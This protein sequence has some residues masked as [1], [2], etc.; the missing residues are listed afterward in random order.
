MA[1]RGLDLFRKHFTGL[2][3]R[4]VIIGGTACVLL[5][6]E[7][8]LPFRAT[9]DL[10][11]VLLVE[12]LDAEFGRKFWTFVKSGGYRLQEGTRGKPRLYRFQK[13]ANDAYPAMVELFSRAPDALPIEPAGRRTPIPI[14]E[15]ISSLSAI[16]LDADYYAWIQDG[17]R[18]IHELPVVDAVHLVP[19]KA[20]AW[21]DLRARAAAGEEIDSRS[22]RKHKNDIFR[23]FQ[24]I[25]PD[26]DVKPPLRIVEDMRSF[27]EQI[28]KEEVDLKALGLTTI[29]RQAV[30]HG[31]R[32]LYRV[33]GKP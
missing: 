1:V 20:K 22:I 28:V 12:A 13:P 4:Y 2:S 27:L 26:T 33:E 8:G 3:D 24:V 9:K 5:M 14:D 25:A 32:R 31:L 7:A 16:L 19:L 30:L 11:I 29:S 21:M 17:R 23:L 15:E 10:D 6:E 18:V